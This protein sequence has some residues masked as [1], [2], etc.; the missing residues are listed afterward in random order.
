MRF[1]NAQPVS[2]L[3]GTALADSGG[4][5][6]LPQ[7]NNTWRILASCV[8]TAPSCSTRWRLRLQM[9][10]TTGDQANDTAPRD[11]CAQ[12]GSECRDAVL[13]W[14]MRSLPQLSRAAE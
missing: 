8:N 4:M 2:L 14:R 12:P 1:A 10:T 11:T 7:T 6:R 9:G 13:G 3:N 5:G